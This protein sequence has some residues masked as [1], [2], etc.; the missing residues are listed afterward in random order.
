MVRRLTN[1][2]MPQSLLEMERLF[3]SCRLEPEVT[4]ETIHC[5][6]VRRL[7]LVVRLRRKHGVSRIP[8]WSVSRCWV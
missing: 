6:K 7:S 8:T 4:K 5:L 1:E 2:T 3:H